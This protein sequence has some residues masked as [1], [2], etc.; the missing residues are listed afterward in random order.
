MM[1]IQ[2]Q[3]MITDNV[4]TCTLCLETINSDRDRGY[5]DTDGQCQ[6]QHNYHYNC[7]SLMCI[8]HQRKQMNMKCQECRQQI[9]GILDCERENRYLLDEH[10]EI[11][12]ICQDLLGVQKLNWVNDMLMHC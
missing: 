8:H 12:P 1:T 10:E 6:C 5:A 9:F 2:M 4:L 3:M 11:C 7:L